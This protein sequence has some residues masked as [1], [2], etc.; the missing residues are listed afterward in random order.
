MPKSF[1]L[2]RDESEEKIEINCLGVSLEKE[3][4]KII[5]I[6]K[7][8]YLLQDNALFVG[9]VV[10]KECSVEF[11]KYKDAVR[12]ME[13]WKHQIYVVT[14][15]YK[16]LTKDER[17]EDDEWSEVNCSNDK[18]E[19]IKCNSIGNLFV[20]KAGIL[21]G[22]GNCGDILN[23][24]Y[25]KRVH[26]I[27]DK[28]VDVSAGNDFFVILTVDD[29]PYDDDETVSI[30]S[31]VS[32][33]STFS[34]KF[35]KK[36][37]DAIR[38]KVCSL[39]ANNDGGVLGTG[40]HI[41]RSH[42]SYIKSLEGE[43]VYK[44]SS[45]KEHTVAR[46]IDGR[47]FH[48]GL[49]TK[50]QIEN[51]E[52]VDFSSPRELF[53]KRRD[54]VDFH[55]ID[56][57]TRFV[58]SSDF[59]EPAEYHENAPLVLASKNY[60]LYNQPRSIQRNYEK[61]LICLQN[62]ITE[63]LHGRNFLPPLNCSDS[64]RELISDFNRITMIISTILLDFEE[65]Y[66]GFKPVESIS[67]IEFASEI[68][69][70]LESYS[71]RYCDCKSVAELNDEPL[72]VLTR[73][74]QLI[75]SLLEFLHLS[76]MTVQQEMYEKFSRKIAVAMELAEES[77]QF[78]MKHWKTTP[79]LKFKSPHRRFVLDS[80]RVPIKLQTSVKIYSPTHNFILF[81]DILVQYGSAVSIYILS[82]VWVK[83]EGELAF[84]KSSTITF[85]YSYF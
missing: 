17:D 23:S 37:Y 78:W 40:D 65:F 56:N 15:D 19:S 57:R 46:T 83:I 50:G 32:V 5:A 45:G 58:Y 75:D 79:I 2:F 54:I 84:S 12:D 39:G 22:A 61:F 44:I 68:I 18:I 16:V 71:N 51:V 73:P 67:F 64:V 3:V 20:S 81:S 10:D 63:C 25:P 7:K 29:F 43:G 70:I 34:D 52:Q 59:I 76:Q 6:S 77:R 41:K 74:I 48:W 11:R 35:Y 14:T 47:I 62:T 31:L 24:D 82:A 80:E 72:R 49:N 36:G 69:E 55:C 9:K 53:P 4:R 42:L 13:F 8:I 30:A 60:T 38:T 26:Q 28:V 21:Y 27:T 33:T 85:H 66:F 1:K